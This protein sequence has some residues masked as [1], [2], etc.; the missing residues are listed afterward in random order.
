MVLSAAKSIKERENKKILDDKARKSSNQVHHVSGKAPRKSSEPN[1]YCATCRKTNHNTPEFRFARKGKHQPRNG[2]QCQ[3][4][5]KPNYTAEKSF[6]IKRLK[7]NNQVMVAT[8]ETENKAFG[9]NIKN[10]I[11]NTN[12]PSVHWMMDSGATM[13]ITNTK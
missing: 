3:Y 13:H 11:T 9:M 1:M 2:I 10:H 5:G 8:H 6:E 7:K 4:C 12:C